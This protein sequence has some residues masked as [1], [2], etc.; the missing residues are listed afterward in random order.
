MKNNRKIQ[1]EKLLK[2]NKIKQ[3]KKQLIADLKKYRGIDIS[4]N[5]FVDGQLSREAH[6]KVYQLVKADEI[7]T[8]TFAYHEEELKSKIALIYKG[9]ENFSEETVLF[10]PFTF[11]FYVKSSHHLY[12]EH[13]IAITMPLYATKRMIAKLVPDIYDDVVVVSETFE[14]G[15]VLSEDEYSDVTIHYWGI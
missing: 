7:K 6:Q 12:L 8:I 9:F 5:E 15:F 13:P 11:C 3:A 1:L 10:Y 4:Q 2:E 14:F